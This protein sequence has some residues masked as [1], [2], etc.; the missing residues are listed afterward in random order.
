MTHSRSWFT[1]NQVGYFVAILYALIIAIPVYFVVISG[2]KDH[3]EVLREP[4]APPTHFSF[5]NFTTAEERAHLLEAMITTF[6]IVASAEGLNLALGFLAAYAIARIRLPEAYLVEGIFSAGFLVPAFAIIV[7]I[8]LLATD[9]GMLYKPSYLITFYAVSLLPLTIVILASNMRQIPPDYEEAALIDGANRLQTIWHIFL[10]L[11]RSAV[12]TVLI[13]NFLDIWNEYLFALILLPG[14]T[15]TIQ[16][17]VPMLRSERSV[18]YG[19]IAAGI[20]I[21]LIPVYIIFIL[22]QER[23]VKGMTAGGIKS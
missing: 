10:P 15:K 7:P 11:T 17:A 5:D 18:D 2:F 16:L 1:V 3:S 4:L 23:I 13:L 9:L 19:L 8:F 21:S 12:S 20:T 22:F 14:N 6:K